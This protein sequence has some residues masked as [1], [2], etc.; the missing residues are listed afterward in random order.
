MYLLLGN[1]HMDSSDYE[2]AIHLFERAQAQMR[3]YEDQS[4]LAISLV[5]FLMV[6]CN[7]SK[8]LTDSDR[9]PDGN[10]MIST[11]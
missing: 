4:L 9:Y 3:H 6:H 11:S 10:L 8:S 5:S 2:G 7:V 1:S